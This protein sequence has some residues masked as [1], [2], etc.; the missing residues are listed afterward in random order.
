MMTQLAAPFVHV[1]LFECPQ[2]GCLVSCAI[3]NDKKNSEEV[4]SREVS[5]RCKCQW[6]GTM[7]GVNAKRHLVL[8]WDFFTDNRG[9]IGSSRNIV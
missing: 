4:D 7:L 1:L 9:S 2:C 8:D 6:S 3:T 5:L